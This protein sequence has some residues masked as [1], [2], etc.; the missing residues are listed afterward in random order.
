MAKW[1]AL[2]RLLSPLG[3]FVSRPGREAFSLFGPQESFNET[4]TPILNVISHCSILLRR[5]DAE[6]PSLPLLAKRYPSSLT[7]RFEY[8]DD[9]IRP[10]PRICHSRIQFVH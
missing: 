8:S 10:R 4:L 3:P 2:G 5:C 9:K 7:G 1:R 6:G